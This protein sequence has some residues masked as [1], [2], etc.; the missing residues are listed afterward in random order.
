[1]KA[2]HTKRYRAITGHEEGDHKMN[3]LPTTTDTG[4]RRGWARRLYTDLKGRYR[5]VCA[6]AVATLTASATF[7][8]ESADSTEH[9]L[10]GPA[11]AVT[12]V[13]LMALGASLALLLPADVA[14][15]QID[16]N[17]GINE[18][19]ST[20]G[21]IGMGLGVVVGIGLL[22]AKR[23]MGMLGA[24]L[25]GGLVYVICENPEGTIGA[26]AEWLVNAF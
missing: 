18:V 1:M 26:A 25:A 20:I 14:H 22:C 6:C 10:G 2:T 19:F 23:I 13:A 3:D 15:A 17:K 4:N 12:V 9:R 11:R 8:S 16:P 24:F 7:A 21:K 5:Q